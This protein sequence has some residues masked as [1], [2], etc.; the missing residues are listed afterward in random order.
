MGWQFNSKEPV[1]LQIADRLRLGILRGDYG[2]PDTQFPTV[3]ALA[4]TSG[5]NPNT[6][7]RALAVLEEEGLLCTKGTVGRFVTDNTQTLQTAAESARREAVRKW[8]AEAKELGISA[9]TLIQ[10]IQEEETT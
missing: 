4:E 6:V 9:K 3:R 1:F 2:S 7:Q 8:L 10:Y 5:A